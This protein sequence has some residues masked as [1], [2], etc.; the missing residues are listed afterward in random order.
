M[1]IGQEWRANGRHLERGI[2]GDL[3]TDRVCRPQPV[4]LTSARRG[5]GSGD[6]VG[7][8]QGGG[9]ETL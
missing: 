1:C 7:T 3:E 9:M 5:D 4:R 2:W 8:K 6:T